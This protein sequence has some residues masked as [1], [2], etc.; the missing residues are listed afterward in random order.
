MASTTL[1]VFGTTLTGFV[2]AGGVDEGEDVERVQM[3]EAFG[4]DGAA[5][6]TGGLNPKDIRVVVHLSGLANEAA[7]NSHVT[8]IRG[9]TGLSGTV[10]VAGK[11]NLSWT[12]C[13]LLR[14]EDSGKGAAPNPA[15]GGTWHQ[16]ITLRFVQLR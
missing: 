8:A 9:L 2:P 10:T 3:H 13:L 12:N 16:E 7:L 14:V 4:L 5:A 15:A 11:R 6:I 1:T